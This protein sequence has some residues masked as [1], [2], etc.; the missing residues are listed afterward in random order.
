LNEIEFKLL[1][2]IDRYSVAAAVAVA[3][4]F[5]IKSAFPKR[6]ISSNGAIY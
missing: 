1:C 3:V 2:N 6:T 4:A 5:T